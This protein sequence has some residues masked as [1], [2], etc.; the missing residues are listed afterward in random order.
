MRASK[1]TSLLWRAAGGTL[2]CSWPPGNSAGRI[3][4]T[5]CATPCKRGCLQGW[6]TGNRFIRGSHGRQSVTLGLPGF[7]LR[8]SG[9]LGSWSDGA[10]SGGI[11]SRPPWQWPSGAG[12]RLAVGLGHYLQ[13]WQSPR[14]RQSPPG[15]L[16]PG[17]P[18]HGWWLPSAA[19]LPGHLRTQGSTRSNRLAN[20]SRV[21][22]SLGGC[23]LKRKLLLSKLKNFPSR[24][25]YSFGLVFVIVQGHPTLCIYLEGL[26]KGHKIFPGFL[27]IIKEIINQLHCRLYSAAYMQIFLYICAEPG[28][29]KWSKINGHCF[30]IYMS[31][32]LT[33]C[34]ISTQETGI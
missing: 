29:G 7:Y 33:S 30:I 27:R 13:I 3:C 19:S 12:T 21:S 14:C 4:G 2:R 5:S 32:H 28:S 9:F 31:V 18:G 1:G 6:W 23:I 26:L 10:A 8:N 11:C 20:L 15:G 16:G 22:L 34:M 24:S 17:G 25:F